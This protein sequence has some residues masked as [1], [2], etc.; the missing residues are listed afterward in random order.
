MPGLPA[1]KAGDKEAAATAKSLAKPPVKPG[2]Q[3]LHWRTGAFD[4][5]LT[6]GARLRQAQAS[7]LAGHA[8]NLRAAHQP[9]TLTELSKEAAAILSE[10]GHQPGPDVMRRVAMT[11]EGLAAQGPMER[12]RLAA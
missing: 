11:P 2:C 12:Q 8:T 6:A 10:S 1:R 4:R 7:Q 5:L 9:R 3:R